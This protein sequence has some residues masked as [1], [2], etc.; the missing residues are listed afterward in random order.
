MEIHQ[1]DI[2]VQGYKAC[3]HSEKFR[4]YTDLAARTTDDA[5]RRT[6][7]SLAQAEAVHKLRFELEY[8]T[9]FM[10]EG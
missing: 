3:A 9:R 7:S 2:E 4:L 5:L 1:A 10:P 8:E 6:F